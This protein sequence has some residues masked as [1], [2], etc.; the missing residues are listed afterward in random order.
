[1]DPLG[2]VALLARRRPVLDQHRVDQLAD[3]VEDRHRPRSATTR[4]RDRRADRLAHRAPVHPVLVGQ[5]PDRHLIA[6]GIEPNRRVQLHPRPHPGPYARADGRATDTPDDPLEQ[7]PSPST[8]TACRTTTSR[9]WGQLRVLRPHRNTPQVGPELRRTAGPDQ[10][11]TAKHLRRHSLR[12][13]GLTWIADAGVPVH[14]LRKIAGHGSIT[15]TQRYLKS[16]ELH[17]MSEKPQV[18]CSVRPCSGV[19]RQLSVAT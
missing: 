4:R 13:T 3:R 5:R 1:M 9:R 8:M 14:V 16:Q 15:T 6:L 18:A 7:P 17:Q 11:A 10:S 12:H 2:G 19:P